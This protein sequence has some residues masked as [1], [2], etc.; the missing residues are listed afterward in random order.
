MRWVWQ[1]L[2]ATDWNNSQLTD[3]PTNKPNQRDSK[4]TNK[5]H[6]LIGKF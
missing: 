2:S 6:I 4:V 5:N 3:T 1:K